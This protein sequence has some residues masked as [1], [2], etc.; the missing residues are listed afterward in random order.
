MKSSQ[1]IVLFAILIFYLLPIRDIK[2]E[3]KVTE[4]DVSISNNRT[5]TKSLIN[6]IK[7]EEKKS[8]VKFGNFRLRGIVYA[9]DDKETSTSRAII[10]NR[11]TSITNTYIVNSLLPDNS[12]LVSIYG[13]KVIIK[14]EGV[15]KEL[16]FSYDFTGDYRRS[17]DKTIIKKEGVVKELKL[18][19][20]FTD[21]Y[22]QIDE[23]S[24]EINP[25]EVF[26]G[27][28]NEVLSGF[29]IEPYYE[30]GKFSGLKAVNVFD[31]KMA[32]KL[33]I[34]ENDII[35]SVNGERVDSLYNLIKIGV[36]ARNSDVIK[37]EIN[38]N[39]KTANLNYKFNWNGVS[40]WSVPDF[41]KS[42]LV[43]NTIISLGSRSGQKE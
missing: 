6:L 3:Q 12:R 29:E 4:K 43:Q 2:A 7:L 22:R 35:K 13:D 34:N 32:A 37:L 27:D 25:N 33:G 21:G 14:K 5:E 41:M 26:T 38:R 20:D 16:E 19:Y 30:D 15:I 40:E 1:I 23:N 17:R 28:I 9:K 10:K 8:R 39:G 42:E 31:D 36:T 18:S 24:W 11:D